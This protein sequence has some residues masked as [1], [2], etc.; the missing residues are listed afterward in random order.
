[1]S[2]MMPVNEWTQI[3]PIVPFAILPMRPNCSNPIQFCVSSV[4]KC[5]SSLLIELLLKG[6]N[7]GLP[8][9]RVFDFHN[10]DSSKGKGGHRQPPDLDDEVRNVAFWVIWKAMSWSDH[11][12]LSRREE[13]CEDGIPWTIPDIHSGRW[14]SSVVLK[15]F[16][17]GHVKEHLLLENEVMPIQCPFGLSK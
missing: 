8:V 16:P 3:L 6:W 2:G 9:L 17:G 10:K 7:S 5:R 1:M 13:G 15:H 14:V 11:V 12:P 4:C